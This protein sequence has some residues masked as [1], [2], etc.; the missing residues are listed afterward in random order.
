MAIL[1]IWAAS[2][3]YVWPISDQKVLYKDNLMEKEEI[4]MSYQSTLTASE[5]LKPSSTDQSA[6]FLAKRKQEVN[7]EFDQ[8]LASVSDSSKTCPLLAMSPIPNI[9]LP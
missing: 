9:Y 3:K 5:H 4:A 2:L 1:G 6:V 8:L 7:I